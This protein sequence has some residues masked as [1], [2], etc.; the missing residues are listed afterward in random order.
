[1]LTNKH[2]QDQPQGGKSKRK[3]K[4]IKLSK[5]SKLTK[6]LIEEFDSFLEY[7]SPERLSRNL[8]NLFISHLEYEKDH[9][10]YF[11]DLIGD[12]YILF[13]LLDLSED[14]MKK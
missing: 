4:R 3:R 2:Q 5:N 1:M 10:L 6:K 11:D 12:L 8:R 7:V 9:P 14:E 13:Q